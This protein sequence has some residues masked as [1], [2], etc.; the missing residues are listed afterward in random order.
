[1]NFSWWTPPSGSNFSPQV[2]TLFFSLVGF[3]ALITGGVMAFIVYFCWK[4]RAGS[5]ADR[6]DRKS[7]N[8]TLE[9]SWTG[10]PFVIAMV[11]FVLGAD[12]YFDEFTP[13]A[14]SLRIYTIGKQWMWKFEH[15]EGQREINQLHLPLGRPIE[16]VMI[17][18]DVIH[19][20]FIPAFRI[21]HDLLPDRYY[22]E[23]FTPT[24]LGTYDL[25]CSQYCGT[26]HSDMRA[27]VIVMP[28]QQYARWLAHGHPQ[29]TMAQRG[30]R[31]FI[32]LGCS[33]CHGPASSVHA[34][35]LAGIYDMPVPLSNHTIVIADDTYLRDSI[36][37]P[38]SQIV[39]GFQHI[40]PSYKGHV[41]EGEILDLIEFIKSLG[42]RERRRT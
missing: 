18:Q 33:G 29:G 23:W 41:T 13:P 42:T 16:L 21:H 12:L 24:R 14:N 9:L 17:S 7:N 19:D 10:I 2:D 22:S 8:L 27:D 40:M 37:L 11:F 34:P 30:S 39:A 32:R 28:P 35:D 38:N 36:L 6:S 5:K 4:Y 15:P 31:L 1:M 25:L 20:V 26:F 3:T